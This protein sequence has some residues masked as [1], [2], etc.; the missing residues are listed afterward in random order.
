MKTARHRIGVFDMMLTIYCGDHDELV[1]AVESSRDFAPP[2]REDWLAFAAHSGYRIGLFFPRQ[3]THGIIAH[4]ISHAVNYVLEH[5]GIVPTTSNDEMQA[6][7]HEEL[8]D[9]VYFRLKQWKVAP[10]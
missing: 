6:L 9:A 5:N 7:L 3:L 10:R 2:D 1:A 8:H 4:E